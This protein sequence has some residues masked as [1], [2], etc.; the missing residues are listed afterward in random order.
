MHASTA[1]ATEDQQR[2]TDHDGADARP[3]R[4]VDRLLSFTDNSIGPI[5]ASWVSLV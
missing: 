1:L 2:A 5:F 4:H 3:N